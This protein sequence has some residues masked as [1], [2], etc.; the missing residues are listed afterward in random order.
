MNR[1]QL[2]GYIPND[3]FFHRLSGSSKLIAFLLLSVIGMVSYDTR[4]LLVLGMGSFV[5]FRI[6]QIKLSEISF[7]LK[8]IAFFSI[9][10]LLTVYLFSPE[11]GVQ[12]Y[13]SRHLIFSGISRFTLTQEQLFYE[14][15]LFIKYFCTIPPALVFLIT[16]DPSEFASSLN[17]IGVSYKVSYSVSLA[18]RYIP[19]V[20]SDFQTI[21]QASQARGTE[22][23]KKA[24][25]LQRVKGNVQIALP[26]I[27]TSLDRITTISNAMELR[28]FGRGK[29]RSWYCAKK[30]TRNDYLVIGAALLIF[31]IGLSLIVLNGGRFYNP[32][33]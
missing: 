10:N 12:L 22:L 32:F 29:K 6:A 7:V 18:L 5:I 26:L 11:Y 9:L 27:F 25:L 23:S 33:Q 8:F 19:D 14:L 16:T 15:N 2:I 21:S 3:T 13:G 24:K 20:Q 31:C 4:F 1:D 17:K 28:R 30:M